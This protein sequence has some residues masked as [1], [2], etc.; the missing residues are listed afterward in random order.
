MPAERRIIL[1]SNGSVGA[2]PSNSLTSFTNILPA[3][4]RMS[5][6]RQWFAALEVLSVHAEFVE[7]AQ[8]G[9]RRY[10]RR[11]KRPPKYIR[12]ILSNLKPG[13]GSVDYQNTL[14]V[15][16]LYEAATSQ[17]GRHRYF[18]H[19]VDRREFVELVG[20]SDITSLSIRLVDEHGEQL[21]VSPGQPTFVRI[22]LQKMSPSSNFMLRVSNRDSNDPLATN[23]SFT[24]HLGA[25]LSLN[26]RWRVALSS[27]QFPRKILG[28]RAEDLEG[29]DRVSIRYGM[30]DNFVDPEPFGRED[31]VSAESL[32]TML[33][34]QVT[35]LDLNKNFDF[36]IL[37][38]G[39]LLVGLKY[40]ARLSVSY[41]L[42]LVL[43]LVED[44]DV[45]NDGVELRTRENEH[46][47]HTGYHPIDLQ[48]PATMLLYTDIIQSTSLGDRRCPILKLI[49]TDL[50]QGDSVVSYESRHLDFVNLRS[51]HIASIAFDL[52]R[53]DGHHVDFKSTKAEV[54]YNLV[55]RKMK[56]KKRR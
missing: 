31:F 47:E 11:R 49:P 35:L 6:R 48:T 18:Y 14:A 40:P 55:F 39:R 7:Y 46:L 4:I 13:A 54:M 26:G 24:V 27:V 32:L 29:P 3:P 33:L 38:D 1:V 52:R 17:H 30:H 28:I 19:E 16:P 20:G 37:P 21:H 23:S 41:K 36:I 10:R 34:H 9:R 8:V 25:P 12:V 45:H 5:H 42:A 43:G 53:F 51:S 56:K 22:F 50:G 2:F 44:L 15:L